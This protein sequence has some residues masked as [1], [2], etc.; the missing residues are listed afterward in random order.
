VKGIQ[1][2]NNNSTVKIKGKLHKVQVNEMNVPRENYR[3]TI[4]FFKRESSEHGN[5]YVSMKSNI[6]S[7]KESC[8]NK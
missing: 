2:R 8:T 5:A 6:L 4:V 7:L 3:L 1:T